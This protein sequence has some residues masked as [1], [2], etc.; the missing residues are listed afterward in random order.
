MEITNKHCTTFNRHGTGAGF[1]LCF[2][3]K[4][5]DWNKNETSR[6]SPK[7]S[8]ISQPNI[9]RNSYVVSF[10]GPRVSTAIGSNVYVCVDCSESEYF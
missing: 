2:H 3:Q 6:L 7:A 10:I 4:M 8:D 9:L 5:T 1:T